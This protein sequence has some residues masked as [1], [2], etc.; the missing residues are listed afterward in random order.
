MNEPVHKQ[1]GSSIVN[2]SLG[3]SRVMILKAKTDYVSS[4]HLPSGRMCQKVTLPHNS[5]FVLGWQSNRDFLHSTRPDKRMASL[6]SFD[7]LLY[8]EQR[9][10]LTF[11]TIATFMYPSIVV[12]DEQD[13]TKRIVVVGQVPESTGLFVITSLKRDPKR[14]W[15]KR[16][17]GK[18]KMRTTKTTTTVR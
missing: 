10:S 16:M 7:E 17:K 18:G 5:L 13:E 12:T 8:G 9:I 3:A 14:N 6:K 1:T 15:K 4:S 11:R 2:L